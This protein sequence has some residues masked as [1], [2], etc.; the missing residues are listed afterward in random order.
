[1][2]NKFYP[3]D[4]IATETLKERARQM[5]REPTYCEKIIWN[6]VRDNRLGVK[7]RRQF[8][9]SYYIVDFICMEKKLIIEIDGASHYGNEE[10][11]KQRELELIE[12]GYKVM[13]FSDE[14][15]TGNGNKVVDKIVAVL[16]H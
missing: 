8:I 9:I 16:G 6:A 3:E 7:F 4:N 11:D 12:M 5:R 14:E 15:V 10:Y 13:R 1:M 2:M